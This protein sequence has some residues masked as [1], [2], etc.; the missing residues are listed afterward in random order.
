[1]AGDSELEF[2]ETLK[3]QVKELKD[4]VRDHPPSIAA[5]NTSPHVEVGTPSEMASTREL[6]QKLMGGNVPRGMSS[7]SIFPSANTG[8]RRWM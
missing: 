6:L 1:M 7:K 4:Q 5:T 3:A 8:L 2:G